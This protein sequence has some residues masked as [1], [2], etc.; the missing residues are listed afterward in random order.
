MVCSKLEARGHL[1]HKTGTPPNISAGSVYELY[2]ASNNTAN[3][4]LLWSSN[5]IN[6]MLKFD[7][8]VSNMLSVRKMSNLSMRSMSLFVTK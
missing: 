5:D 3:I 8:L 7:I 1:L 6:F 2:I 4:V